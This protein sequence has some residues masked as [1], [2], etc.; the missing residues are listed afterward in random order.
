MTLNDATRLETGATPLG[1]G[2]T[3]PAWLRA[4][5]FVLAVGV[6]AASFVV[7]LLLGAVRWV[8]RR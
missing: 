6:L 4:L 2:G 3:Q 1:T 5:L 7:E 8:L